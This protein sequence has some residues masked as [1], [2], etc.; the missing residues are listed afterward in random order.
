MVDDHRVNTGQILQ[1]PAGTLIL[2]ERPSDIVAVHN[3]R[4]F[5]L[6]THSKLHVLTSD[7]KRSLA[8]HALAGGS[9]MT[10]LAWVPQRQE[11]LVST[12]GNDVLRFR[13]S[14]GRLSPT[15]KL[16]FPA[17]RDRR[18]AY[19]AGI[20]VDAQGE[21]AYIALN[22]ANQV[23]VV[24]LGTG[25]TVKTFDTAPA[26]F[27]VAFD[28]VTLAVTCWGRWPRMGL[29]SA[30]SSGTPVQVQVT[31]ASAGG[32]LVTWRGGRRREVLVGSQPTVPILRGE[33]VYFANANS[34]EV[35]Y[36]QGDRFNKLWQYRV[37]DAPTSLILN[38]DT[39][40]VTL[41]GQNR[42]VAHDLVSGRPLASSPT[43]WYPISAVRTGTGFVVASA[44]GIGSR[45][46]T[47]DRR[48]VYQFTGAV[49]PVARL[50]PGTLREARADLPRA[51]APVRVVPER[52]GEP[53]PIRHV[54]YV[55]KENRTYDQVFGNLKEG[56]GEPKLCIFPE[57]VTPNHHALAR[58]FALLDNY[59]CMGVLSADGHSWSTEGLASSYFERSFGGWTRAYPFG[60]EPLAISQAGHIWDR[61]LDR[62][63]TFV[64]FGEYDYA[65]PERGQT[66]ASLMRDF[67]AGKRD[68]KFT[69]KIG[70]ERLRKHS[71]PEFPG[72]N[73]SIP[74]LIRADIFVRRV[75][76]WDAKGTHP[77][78]TIV[79]LP[80]DHTSGRSPGAPT[81]EAHMADND[82]A[83]GKV[84][85]RISRSKMW[86]RT[87]IF[88]VE[89]DPQDGFD[90]V[91]G[92]RSLCLVVSPYTRR[93][94]VA[95]Q[96]FNQASVLR[97]M[98]HMLGLGPL[99]TFTET[100]PFMTSV[101]SGSANLTPY[102]ARPA[103]VDLQAINPAARGAVRIDLAKPDTT[104]E[105][106]FNREI[107]TAMRPGEPY[108][109]EWAGAHGRGLAVRGLR[110]DRRGVKSA[111]SKK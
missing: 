31:G 79:Y 102:Q 69:H 17:T 39:L 82:L 70:V 91:D 47:D 41:G 20:S 5:A 80:Q 111:Q 62:G 73:M 59:Y 77:N 86:P 36:M 52:V 9:G 57:R 97:T 6:K 1:P 87:A 63:L 40:V 21:R 104:D 92:H 105:D 11:L 13:W 48:G 110:L 76:E 100:A 98:R 25:E 10:G 109:K 67:L 64:N 29:P 108:P 54:V 2:P 23:A 107:W 60:D 3:G 61:V 19:P 7:G 65:E 26:P 37:G 14:E 8:S 66:H 68:F 4:F 58:E 12:A 28:G 18:A 30:D 75:D 90:H 74:D 71:D 96:F 16:T 78:F 72:W 53:S 51:N 50:A 24:D 84:V 45:S 106:L 89:D 43:A 42:L 94:H 95:R 55:I 49:S 27:G 83:L 44:K 93:G 15:G 81:P 46:G 38:P 99:S 22:R 88:V 85:E 101:F 33:R 56:R 35:G 34:G 103:Q 32:T